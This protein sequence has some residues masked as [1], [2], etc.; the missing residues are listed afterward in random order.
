MN[1]KFRLCISRE[2]YDHKPTRED[3]QRIRFESKT[4]NVEE[5][6]QLIEEGYAYTSLMKDNWRSGNNFICTNL[7]TFDIDH[8]TTT[9]D[10]CIEQLELKPTVA[11]TSSRNGLEGYGFGYRL[12]YLV[13]EEICTLVEYED[14]SKC[15]SE[16]LKLESVDNRSYKGDQMWFGCKDCSVYIS[17]EKI[18]KEN[19]ILKKECKKRNATT[20]ECGCFDS[21][22]LIN[23]ENNIINNKKDFNSNSNNTKVSVKHNTNT[24]N[25]LCVSDTFI[26][27]YWNL[28]LSDILSKYNYPNLMRTNIEINED[29]P[30]VYYPEDYIEISRPWKKINGETL[31][32]SDG[33]NRRKKL[34]I[35][36]LLRRAINPSI[37]FDNLLY[38]IVWEFYNYYI[39]NGNRIDKKTLYSIVTNAMKQDINK[40]L[41]T[42]G[43]P[44][45]KFFVNKLYCDKYGLSPKQVIGKMRNKKQYIGEFYDPLLTDKENIDVMKE[46]GLDISIRTL[47]R[48]KKENNIRKY[49]K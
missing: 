5:F 33:N 7:I 13:D 26:N 37:T 38:N 45:Y 35:N 30:I 44:R 49:N 8:S 27:D 39:N 11:Y 10:D 21:S 2:K 16:Q 34:Y 36:A 3:C 47:K 19:I 18:K 31:K 20:S 12:V 23:N 24:Q 4:V 46:Y 42:N 17:N 40:T 9:M 14:L 25:I 28:S 15:L 41:L 22:L 1:D 6:V 32:I 48:W 43:K 29:E